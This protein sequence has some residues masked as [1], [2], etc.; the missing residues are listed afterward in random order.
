[1]ND[2][3]RF[4]VPSREQ[5]LLAGVTRR[6]STREKRTKRGK[7]TFFPGNVYGGTSRLLKIGVVVCK[8]KRIVWMVDCQRQI[9][10][11]ATESSRH[12]RHLKLPNDQ[13]YYHA[14][15]EEARSKNEAYTGLR[16]AGVRC[17]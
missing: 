15:L 5:G 17:C 10:L 13:C 8:C 3:R 12:T 6:A 9:K 16:S 14:A 7:L 2:G 11:Q 4:G 1:M